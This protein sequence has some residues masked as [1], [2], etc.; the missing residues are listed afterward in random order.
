VFGV[1]PSPVMRGKAQARLPELSLYDGDFL[2]FPVLE[3]TVQT[4]VSSYA[5]HHLTDDEKRQAVRNYGE[6]LPKGGKIV[7]ADTVFK[8]ETTKEE[9]FQRV[10]GQNYYNLLHDLQT[11]YYP[12]LNL[13]KSIFADNGFEAS[14]SQLNRYVWLIEA[15]KS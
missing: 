12:C 13:L 9:L 11:E 5:F 14:Y 2:Q 6:W 1:E 4:I 7:F 8:D 10:K 15:E 3:A